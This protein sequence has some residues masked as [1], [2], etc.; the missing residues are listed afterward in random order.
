MSE[1]DTSDIGNRSTKMASRTGY[2]V[3]YDRKQGFGFIRAERKGLDKMSKSIQKRALEGQILIFY[4]PN[5]ETDVSLVEGMEVLFDD[6]Q[7]PKGFQVWKVAEHI[8]LA[9][10]TDSSADGPGSIPPAPAQRR[11]TTTQTVE[12]ES[13]YEWE[14][15]QWE[16]EET[17]Y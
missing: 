2:L 5:I 17:E 3:S 13:G 12:S 7:Q 14:A 15:A 9:E 8:R 16:A 1:A 11:S 6:G 10:P 4:E